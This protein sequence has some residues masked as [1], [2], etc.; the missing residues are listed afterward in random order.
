MDSITRYISQFI[1]EDEGQDVVEYGLLI[2]GIAFVVL[3]GV[4]AFGTQVNNWFNAIAAAL[5][6]PP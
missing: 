2:V 5:P 3:V 4:S 6:A 1:R